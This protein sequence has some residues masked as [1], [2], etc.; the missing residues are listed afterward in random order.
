MVIETSA[1][2]QFSVSP[3]EPVELVAGGNVGYP[4]ARVQNEGSGPVPGQD[5]I[6]TLPPGRRLRF[7]PET[8]AIYHLTVFD[9]VRA[10]RN[11]PGNLSPD[12]ATLNFKDVDL[13]IPEPGSLSAL[14]VAVTAAIDAPAGT[15]NLA[16]VVGGRSSNSSAITV[17]PT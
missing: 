2:I 8:G 14:W 15:T 4:G 17:R 7:E 12:G 10:I 13:G 6:V 3:W 16:F 1:Q 5:I 9:H 11:Y